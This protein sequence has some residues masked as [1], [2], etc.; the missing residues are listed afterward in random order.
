MTDFVKLVLTDYTPASIT[1]QENGIVFNWSQYYGW[2]ITCPVL[3]IHLSNL[4]GKD[5]FDVRRMMKILVAYQILMLS[6]ATAALCEKGN[7]VKW[8]FFLLAITCLMIL[9]RYALQ[10]FKES[11]KIMPINATSVLK[12]IAVVFYSSWS[13][14]G[15]FWFLGP[16]G[17]SL[18]SNEIS[19]AGF[20]VCD[21]LSKNIYSMLGWYL[22]WYVL[23]KHDKPEEFVNET[24]TPVTKI[25]ILLVDNDH[26]F[27][28]YFNTIL[29][30]M[31]CQTHT[32]TNINEI[33]I[34]TSK[35]H[36]DMIFINYSLAV[37]NNC[38]IM[39]EIRKY[40]CMI[41]VLAYGHVIDDV[42]V[43]NRHLTG[44]DDFII[45]PFPDSTIKKKIVQWSRRA[46]VQPDFAANVDRQLIKSKVDQVEMYINSIKNEYNII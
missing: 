9:Y 46:S 20:A 44:I 25:T 39:C 23:R 33:L 8:C 35:E 17:I 18:V 38:Q 7:P 13:G 3:L 37:Q 32:A 42:H 6:G 30:Q 15:L 29:Y 19:K 24:E 21:I 40:L 27:L 36:C 41:P 14:F 16:S 31:E 43:Q 4:A 2:L 34:N 1:V 45:T 22:R 26:N 28:H 12:Q 5:V 10:I 11:M